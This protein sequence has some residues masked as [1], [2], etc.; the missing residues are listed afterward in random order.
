MSLHRHPASTSTPRLALLLSCIAAAALTACGGGGGAS[1]ASQATTA[2]A[3]PPT[4]SGTDVTIV[5]TDPGVDAHP[6]F[7]MAAAQ[8]DEPSDVDADGSSASADSA[9]QSFPID[10][11][12]S[13]LSTAG[14]TPDLLAAAKRSQILSAGT[15]Q[16]AA[17][18]AITAAV[19]T[20][21]Q[22]RAAYGLPVLPAAGAALS[23]AAAAALGAGQTIYLVDAY[24]H[25]NAL[26][27]LNRF[28]AKFGLPACTNVALTATSALPLSKASST[29][30]T[31]SVAYT[32]SKGV[33]QTAAPAYNTDWIA[34]IALDVQWAH[35][36][37]PL[38]RI[39][40]IETTDANSNSLLGGIALAN[41]MG[42]GVV[43]MSFGAPEGSWVTANDA[44]FNA[45]GMSYV[46][47]AGDGGAQALWPAVSPKVLA[48]GGTS[49]QWNGSTRH[50]SAWASSGGGVS[51]YE[52]LPVWQSGTVV[53]GAGAAKRRTVSDVAFNANPTTGQYVALTSKGSLV[54][55]WNAYGGTSIGAPQWAG[56]VAVA[57]ARRVAAAKALLGDVHTTLYKT[58]AG[59]ASAYAADFLDIVDG[60]DGSC[61]TCATAKGYDTVTGWGS[62]N[63]AA[64]L[65][66]LVSN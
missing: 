24:D 41:K 30:C 3:T 4:D 16:P 21:A 1:D 63:A 35:A 31:F 7:H 42:A 54:T 50:E 15:A 14:L 57:N 32:S 37:A 2:A 43:S 59:S 10:S 20:P 52:T 38:A 49:L 6:T 51:L 23:A 13:D 60:S 33:L 65:N 17:T 58:I 18:T 46:A 8:L 47:A 56:L 27:D 29:S 45:A 12:V 34:E 40:L 61:A 5:A 39:V 55:N 36:I 53:P 11:S 9:P 25:P 48:V 28:S 22:I 44:S 26:V 62:P 64:L 19:Y 66:A